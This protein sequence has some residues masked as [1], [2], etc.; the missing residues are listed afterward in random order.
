MTV[1]ICVALWLVSGFLAAWIGHKYADKQQYDTTYSTASWVTLLG[2]ASL[3]AV[4]FV[5]FRESN[6]MSKPL[7]KAK[8]PK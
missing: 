6:F 4:L 3:V 8:E 2:L 7:F 5:L 1:A